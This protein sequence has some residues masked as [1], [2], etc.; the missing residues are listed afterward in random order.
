LH[1]ILYSDL[2]KSDPR[3]YIVTWSYD[4]I[5]WITPFTRF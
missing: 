3:M 5:S 1:T 2:L 4:V